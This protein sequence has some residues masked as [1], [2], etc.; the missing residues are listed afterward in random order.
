MS[1]KELSKLVEKTTECI[2]T[3]DDRL[4]GDLQPAGISPDWDV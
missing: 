2:G 4:L 3:Q 1:T